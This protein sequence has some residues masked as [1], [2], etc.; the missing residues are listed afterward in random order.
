MTV[1]RRSRLSRLIHRKKK[2]K[3]FDEWQED[4]YSGSEALIAMGGS[5]I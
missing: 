5:I 4:E 3:S 1:M 2:R